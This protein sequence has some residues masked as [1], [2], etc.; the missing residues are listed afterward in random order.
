[1]KPTLRQTDG[2][3]KEKKDSQG[4]SY[5]GRLEMQGILR[6]HLP[7]PEVAVD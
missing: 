1:M 5:N 2:G 3:K 4:G 7:M 6:I